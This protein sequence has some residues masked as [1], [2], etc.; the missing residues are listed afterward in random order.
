[1]F[2]SARTIVVQIFSRKFSAVRSAKRGRQLTLSDTQ[3]SAIV[4]VLNSAEDA[5]SLGKDYHA[6]R[7]F[8][9]L[10]IGTRV[11]FGGRFN[12]F[13][14]FDQV[15]GAKPADFRKLYEKILAAKNLSPPEDP[16]K[17][18]QHGSRSQLGRGT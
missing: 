4:E 8:A 7:S 1:M 10:I 6:P 3:K 13:Q 11:E 5:E 2:P 15:E 17:L 18:E 9:R 12:S 16:E 14:D